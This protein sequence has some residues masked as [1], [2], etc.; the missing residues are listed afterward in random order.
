MIPLELK[1]NRPFEPYPLLP[2]PTCALKA[3]LSPQ[4]RIFVIQG[5]LKD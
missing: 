5:L 4:G 2:L 1:K 3:I